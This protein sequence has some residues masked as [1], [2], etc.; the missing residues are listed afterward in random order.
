MVIDA[1]A[2][3]YRGQKNLSAPASIIIERYSC[4]L[5]EGAY[6]L[7]K[8]PEFTAAHFA[9]AAD[10]LNSTAIMPEMLHLISMS[11]RDAIEEDGLGEKWELGD[12]AVELFASLTLLEQVALADLVEGFWRGVSRGEQ[13]GPAEFWKSL[14]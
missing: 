13:V 8:R 2:E 5:A 11:V 4:L 10:A 3:T 7:R 6:S 12:G 1:R 14:P 9:C